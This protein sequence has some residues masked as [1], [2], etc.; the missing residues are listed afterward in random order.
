MFANTNVKTLSINDFDDKGNIIN[1]NYKGKSLVLFFASWCGH[2]VNTKPVYMKLANNKKANYLAFD[3]SS[4]D[5]MTKSKM[6]TWKFK[7][8]GFPTI[9]SFYN[10]QPYSTYEGNR[11]VEDLTMYVGNIGRNWKI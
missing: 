1:P 3:M 8:Q 9:I 10:G 5:E 6:S 11:T 2:C 4:P 7:V